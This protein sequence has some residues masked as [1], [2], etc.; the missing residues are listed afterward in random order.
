MPILSMLEN[1]F[2]KLLHRIVTKQEEAKKWSGMICP[3]IKKKLD[4]ITEF[5]AGCNVLCAGGGIFHVTSGELEK[6]Y[7]VDLKGRTCDCNR[8]QLSGIPCHHAIACCRAERIDAEQLVHSCYT[9][10]TYNAAYGYNMVPLRARVHWAKQNGVQIHPPLYTKVMG[11]P[12][13]IGE[14]RQ[15]RKRKKEQRLSQEQD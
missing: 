8:W 7:I 15:K 2:Y 14:R 6:E 10:E 5:A 4:K 12:K 1:I 11:R 3:K 9:I 13:K